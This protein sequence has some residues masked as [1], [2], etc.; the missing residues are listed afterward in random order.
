MGGTMMIS[1]LTINIQANQTDYSQIASTAITLLTAIFTACTAYAAN[2]SARS[3]KKQQ[4]AMVVPALNL[5]KAYSLPQEDRKDCTYYPVKLIFQNRGL[6]PANL[7]KVELD[8]ENISCDI[9]TPV[10]VGPK[11]CTNLKLW[12]D[13]AE[14]DYK[15]RLGLYYADI[16]HKTYGTQ[17]SMIIKYRPPKDGKK[18]P[19]DW[20]I[21]CERII[22]INDG[23]K[24]K[25]KDMIATQICHWTGEDELQIKSLLKLKKFTDSPNISFIQDNPKDPENPKNEE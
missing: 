21:S 8:S 4:E 7:F 2:S 11:N 22:P 24:R 3:M 25:D 20:R 13:K 18:G 1:I 12:L 23:F 16:N 6:G 5:I 14:T 19:A 17:L 9:G 10:G 15:I